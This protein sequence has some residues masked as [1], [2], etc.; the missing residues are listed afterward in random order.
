MSSGTIL[1]ILHGYY[2]IYDLSCV[3]TLVVNSPH[4][5]DN[6][7][8]AVNY[9]LYEKQRSKETAWLVMYSFQFVTYITTAVKSK[10]KT[11]VHLNT[12]STYTMCHFQLTSL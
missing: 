5:L 7:M 3:M 8:A 11:N 2:K 4:R 1:A 6:L 10:I 12:T 9:A